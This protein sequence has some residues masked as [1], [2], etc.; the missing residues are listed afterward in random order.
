LASTIDDLFV[1]PAPTS[2]HGLTRGLDATR[3][4]VRRSPRASWSRDHALDPAGRPNLDRWADRAADQHPS[5]A[6]DQGLDPGWHVGL[7]PGHPVAPDRSCESWTE[8]S[9]RRADQ[10]LRQGRRLP[11]VPA[12][13][14]RHERT[15]PSGAVPG[16]HAARAWGEIWHVDGLAMAL[17]DGRQR[18]LTHPPRPAAMRRAGSA[19]RR[20]AYLL[21][22]PLW[23]TRVAGRSTAS[24]DTPIHLMASP[25]V[26]AS[27]APRRGRGWDLGATRPAGAGAAEGAQ[28]GTH[29]S[30][31]DHRAALAGDR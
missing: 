28:H 13:R 16:R 5:A 17:R 11:R 18:R 12:A 26:R 14:Q 8:T 2:R 29:P 27:I 15:G 10:R 23:N 30:A 24:L 21:V 1:L 20:H 7:R 19:H 4:R 6:S 31:A 22:S 9:H 25:S 3:P